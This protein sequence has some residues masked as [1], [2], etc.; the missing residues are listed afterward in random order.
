M[1]ER[2]GR[3]PVMA[4]V[5]RLAGV[6]HQTV[7]RVLNGHPNVR[8]ETVTRV[9]AAIE[10]L[11]YRR[12]PSARALVTRRTNL[13]GVLTFDSTLFGPARTLA[14]IENAAREAGYFVSV[15]SLDG[16]TR[17]AVIEATARLAEQSV[18]G[19]VALAPQRAVVEALTDLSGLR[20]LVAVEGGGGSGLPVVRVDQEGG[21]YAATRHLLDLGH[22]TVHHI[23]G[24]RDWLEGEARVEGWRRALAEA[25]APVPAP[26]HGDWS[27]RSGYEL[28][29]RLAGERARGAEVT[30]AF[31]AND[32]MSIGVLRAFHENGIEVPGDVSV[33]GFDDIPETEYLTPALTTVRQDFTQLGRSAVELLLAALADGGTGDAAPARAVVPARLRVRESTA[34]ASGAP[35]HW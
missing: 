34:P 18:E 6:S 14:A 9:R 3:T 29:L 5:A 8:T 30:A 1:S 24:K 35:G 33:V 2:D 15:V 21:A 25:G 19:C 31:V 10:E 12:N 11:G 23:A 32:Q 28:G 7:S 20:P 22:R 13:L 27:P 16:V 17:Q 26:A 4:D